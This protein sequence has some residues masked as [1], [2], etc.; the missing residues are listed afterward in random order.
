[1]RVN[2]FW[3]NNLGKFTCKNQLHTIFED[4]SKISMLDDFYSNPS[5]FSFETEISFTLQHYYQIKK[6]L[7]INGRLVCDFSLVDDYAFALV[8]LD[9]KEMHIYNQ[10][11]SY[12]HEHLGKPQKLIR[13]SAPTSELLCRIHNRGR[14][15]ESRID[16]DYLIKFECSLETAIN[17]FYSDVPI[18]TVGTENIMLSDYD[19]VF[20]EKLLT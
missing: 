2:C 4:Y 12:V 8:T 16:S 14:K 1:M 18:I 5:A 20:L 7:G 13:L 19:D 9:D 11:F 3:Q 17:Q 15:N 10:V 6:F